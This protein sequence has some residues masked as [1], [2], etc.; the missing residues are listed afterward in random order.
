MVLNWLFSKVKSYWDGYHINNGEL[1]HLYPRS[2]DTDGS[3]T[4]PNSVDRIG[5]Y[6]FEDCTGLTSISIPNSVTSIGEGAFKSCVSLTSITIPNSVTSIGENVFAGCIHLRR[7]VVDTNSLDEFERIKMLITENRRRNVILLV[8]RLNVVN[9]VTSIGDGAFWNFER[10][11]SIT[12]P[13]SVTSIGRVAF[14][15]CKS[16]TSIN[17]PNSVTNIGR[18]AFGNCESLAFITIPNSVISIGDYAFWGCK[19]L[20]SINI[21]N[22]VA[23]IGDYTFRGCVNLAAITIPNSVT[24][25]GRETFSGCGNIEKIIIDAA[26]LAEFERVKGLLPE[27][28]QLKAIPSKELEKK[29]LYR[30]TQLNTA[31]FNKKLMPIQAITL[32]SK[33]SNA[34]FV[35]EL[36]SPFFGA[37]TKSANNLKKQLDAISCPS[38]MESYKTEVDGLIK[39]FILNTTKPHDEENNGKD[40]LQNG[41]VVAEK[42]SALSPMGR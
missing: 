31:L 39:N 15:N 2:L 28:L 26:N 8:T 10:L 29:N 17:I 5:N 21:P 13:N 24:S 32:G 4:I 42:S 20:T 34:I 25:I 38:D 33:G 16:L 36:T 18:G 1:M 19:S 6:A 22:S 23:S 3:Y 37:K 27:L 40:G 11:T 41:I 12:I 30:D 35:S 9:G 7:I 14:G